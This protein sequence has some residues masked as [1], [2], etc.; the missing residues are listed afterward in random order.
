MCY[1]HMSGRRALWEDVKEI[2]WSR[3]LN[4]VKSGFMLASDDLF[5]NCILAVCTKPP[6]KSKNDSRV[7]AVFFVNWLDC[8]HMKL[9]PC[10]RLHP[11]TK[12]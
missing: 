6:T 2:F 3:P 9:G 10:L 7:L 4:K 8:K 12:L 1:E 11:H 5:S